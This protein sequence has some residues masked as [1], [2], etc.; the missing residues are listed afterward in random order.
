[1]SQFETIAR[2]YAKAIF[3][4][5]KATNSVQSWQEFLNI[6]ALCAEDRNSFSRY[7]KQNF[8]KEFI[9][10]LEEFLLKNRQKKLSDIEKNFLNVLNENNRLVILPEISKQFNFL[11]NE[12][13][14]IIPVKV[15]SA[16]ELTDEEVK[17]IEKLLA[18]K[19]NKELSLEVILE[20]KLIAG[21]RIEY[22]GLVFDQS[23]QGQIEEFGKKLEDLRN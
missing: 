5:A 19:L 7:I 11:F 13:L 20:P 4:E 3:S 14:G 23:I 17:N 2:P 15:F 6:L 21:V 16:K 18:K 1:M 10:W 22:Q 12:E 8:F 9:A